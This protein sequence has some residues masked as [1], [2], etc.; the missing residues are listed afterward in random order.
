M[1]NQTLFNLIPNRQARIERS[2]R[3]LKD[4]LHPT[5]ELAPT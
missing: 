5:S 1:G 4:D 3:V 2:E